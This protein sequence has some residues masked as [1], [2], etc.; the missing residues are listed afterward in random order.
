MITIIV[1]RYGLMENSKLTNIMKVNTI[2]ES[3]VSEHKTC[4]MSIPN[5]K[6]STNIFNNILPSKDQQASKITKCACKRTCP[7]ACI[8][9]VLFFTC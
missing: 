8:M 9:S 7:H 4:K 6:K 2:N 5:I 3:K 1:T